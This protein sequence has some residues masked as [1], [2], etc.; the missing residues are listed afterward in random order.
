MSKFFKSVTLCLAM[1]A[2]PVS[3]CHGETIKREF[4]S[5]WI[6]TVWG[7][8]WPKSGTGTSTSMINAQKAEL[9]EYLEGLAECNFT[10][11]CFQVRARSD[12]F[13]KSSYAPWTSDVSGTRGKDPGWDPLAYAVSEA[14]RLGLE[15]YAWINPYRWSTSSSDHSTSLD[16]QWINDGWIMRY[17]YDD[18]G[19]TKYANYLN[20][21]I[22]G[23][24][25][26]V[27][28]VATELVDGYDIDGL[29]IDDY[30]YP[31]GIP[32]TSSAADYSTWRNSGTNL[33]IG[34]WRRENV[35]TMVADIYKMIQQHK[36]DV[37]FGIGPPGVAGAS[38]SKLGFPTKPASVTA[39][40]WQYD[41][42]YTD[43]LQWLA[44]GTIDFISPQI[45]WTR[46]HSTAPYG[47]LTDWWS[48]CANHAGRH[49]YSSHTIS[50]FGDANTQSNWNERVE[51]IKLNRQYDLNNAP[52]FCL[53]RTAFI[54][55]PTASGFG[56][57]LKNGLT[58]KKSL[59]P[60]VTWKNDDV[61]Q[62]G[63]VT[64]GIHSGATL[65]WDAV[66]YGKRIV[67]YTVYAV[68]MEMA[69]EDAQRADGDGISSDYLLGVTYTNSYQL[70]SGKQNDYWYAVCVYDGFSN[71]FEPS[72]IDYPVEGNAPE[73]T[74]V[75]PADGADVE[76]EVSF[77]WKKVDAE[78]YTLQIASDAAF[79]NIIKSVSTTNASAVVNASELGR[80]K[81]YWRVVS[82]KTNTN[83]TKTASRSFTI[84][85]VEVGSYES[86]YTVKTDGM[87]YANSGDFVL[88]NIWTRTTNLGNFSQSGA[89]A[90][91][92]NRSMVATGDYV[93]VSGRSEN[94]VSADYIYLSK[95]DRY[96]GEH[97]SDV[98]L[99]PSGIVSFYP[100]N[101]VIKD[102][103]GNV[104][105]TNLTINISSTPLVLFKVD[106]DEGSLTQ[107]AELTYSG[108]ES[109]RVDHAAVIG[110]VANGDFTVFAA[111]ASSKY[112]VRWTVKN[113]SV[114]ASS[115]TT[116]GS[117]YPSSAA[118]L[119]IAPVVA[120]I[121]EDNFFVNGGNT[122]LTRYKY[123]ANGAATLVDSFASSQTGVIPDD[124]TFNGGTHF[125]LSG[126]CFVGY[127]SSFNPHR[128]YVVKT[129]G[130][131][132][133]SSMNL[134]WTLPHAGANVF[135][136]HDSGTYQA[137]IDYVADD[138]GNGGVSV[139]TYIPG[140]GLAAYAIKKQSGST[141]LNGFDDR[142][143]PLVTVSGNTIYID[144]PAD[145]ISVYSLSGTLLA[146]GHGKSIA[147]GLQKG[148]YIVRIDI[149]GNQFATGVA[150]R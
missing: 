133:Y 83:P 85:K 24:H 72:L 130:D 1:A 44:S 3:V 69:L 147:T 116:I 73:T 9:T 19:T 125:N 143:P 128:F 66:S 60:V 59:H 52:G 58:A 140:E 34:D 129:N 93:Y 56:T 77:F 36:P 47:P 103:K 32:Q 92:L 67:K 54:N 39:T 16:K 51:Q 64:G 49:H 131:M 88:T 146:K 134:C 144:M 118:N 82:R 136:N 63:S 138:N 12:A 18:N 48:R 135:G 14:H 84:S 21:G 108:L 43:P 30:F 27:L 53:F 132:D 89:T 148:C 137:A 61:H 79:T 149:H 126:S 76:G 65:S 17:S 139:Y 42:Q 23:V 113:G 105:I 112:V 91:T 2:M 11:A 22:A 29:I 70:P 100:C 31:N 55:G 115:H 38:A 102:S 109:T 123:V 121:D 99:W 25:D 50:A 87:T 86:G 62:F 68:P 96:T 46:T 5:T 101:G 75:S 114:T 141:G 98:F 117:F 80:G 7:L 8:D 90:G 35:N 74:L 28:G 26:H 10:S 120:P 124:A 127:P 57:C 4:R 111:V 122:S 150:L 107:V 106:T 97:V 95:Y 33:S 78:S 71:E 142:R 119:G 145:E 15:L 94:S 41:G 104:C 37:R 40:D 110:D 6:S 81:Y 13:Y 20:P 45:Y